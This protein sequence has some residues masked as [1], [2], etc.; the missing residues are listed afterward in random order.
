MLRKKRP[1]LHPQVSRE[2]Y[3]REAALFWG[4]QYLTSWNESL[5]NKSKYTK[6]RILRFPIITVHILHELILVRIIRKQLS[7]PLICSQQ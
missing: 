7:S 5:L 1:F 6:D 4:R 2:R 3:K